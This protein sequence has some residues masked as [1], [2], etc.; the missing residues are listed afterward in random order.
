MSPKNT[1]I[2]ILEEDPI[3]RDRLKAV[4]SE[5]G[6]V[7]TVGETDKALGLLIRQSFRFLLLDWNLVQTDPSS[8]DLAINSFQ[9]KANRAALFNIPQL[10]PVI[11]AMKSGM[12][13]VLWA[14][15]DT[16]VLRN[17]IMDC[18]TQVKPTSVAYSS[19]S[20]LAES[21]SDKAIKQKIT[22]FKARK[23]FSKTFLFQILSLRKMRRDQLAS[24]MNVSSRTLHRH[25]SA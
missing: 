12:G 24:F 25:L 10:N 22:F 6:K 11:G 18:L 15:E 16:T 14:G 13:D 5:F 8:F 1:P 21:I 9:P 19:V 20:Q 7:W 17:K 2:L 4:C 23:E 3:F